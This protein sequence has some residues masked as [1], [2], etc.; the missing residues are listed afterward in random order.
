MSATK[1]K[2]NYITYFRDILIH[3]FNQ[4]NDFYQNSTYTTETARQ[5]YNDLYDQLTDKYLLIPI[6]NDTYIKKQLPLGG[7]I[8]CDFYDEKQFL[9]LPPVEKDGNWIPVVSLR[10]IKKGRTSRSET[11]FRVGLYRKNEEEKVVGFGLRFESPHK[12]GKHDYFHVQL[13]KHW[14]NSK[15]RLI[16]DK[17]P[18]WLPDSQPA[19]PIDAKNPLHL[20]LCLLV[21]LYGI[22][23]AK[24]YLKDSGESNLNKKME[25]M[26]IAGH[27]CS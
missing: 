8:D 20:L 2:D 19:F 23:E 4:G 25:G 26:H 22:K 9:F 17:C 5:K 24:K 13:T 16:S 11:M 18:D 3:L 12:T 6:G 1:K 10:C 21:S 15:K 14:T 7:N 27:L